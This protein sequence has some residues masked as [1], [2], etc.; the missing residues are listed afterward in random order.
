MQ[1][2]PP[3]VYRALKIRD[4]SLSKECPLTVKRKPY[5]TYHKVRVL[6]N[7]PAHN[8]NYRALMLESIAL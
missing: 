4:A 7:V 3:P 5:T 8:L 2:E 1:V 6:I